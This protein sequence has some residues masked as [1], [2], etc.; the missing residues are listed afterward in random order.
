ML[1]FSSPVCL[2]F[3]GSIFRWGISEIDLRDVLGRLA[4]CWVAWILCIRWARDG[5]WCWF[6]C[7]ASVYFGFCWG[8]CCLLGRFPVCL[9]VRSPL[10]LVTSPFLPPFFLGSFFNFT[11]PRACSSVPGSAWSCVA[12]AFVFSPF[13]PICRFGSA[14]GVSR[15]S[16]L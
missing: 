8:V 13:L 14:S 16:F 11:P 10:A 7:S 3:D 1:P 2:V 12:W 4:P 5:H 6:L 15:P 9:M